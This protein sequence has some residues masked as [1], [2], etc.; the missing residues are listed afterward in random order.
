MHH[1]HTQRKHNMTLMTWPGAPVHTRATLTPTT[2]TS[3]SLDRTAYTTDRREPQTHHALL[4]SQSPIDCAQPP[5][6]VSRGPHCTLRWVSESECSRR[7]C[8]MRLPASA[9]ANTPPHH[10]ITEDLGTWRK[11]AHEHAAHAASPATLRDGRRAG[12]PARTSAPRL[13]PLYGA[14]R[15]CLSCDLLR[16]RPEGPP[17]RPPP[18][19]PPPLR[20]PP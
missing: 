8:P 5:T 2:C 11:A 14:G 19:Q 1:I 16:D 4:P 12:L 18:L 10:R 20:P 17:L 9:W 13:C 15:G 6:V 7:A 3:H